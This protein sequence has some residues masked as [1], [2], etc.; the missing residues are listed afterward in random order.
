MKLFF[1]YITIEDKKKTPS[2]SGLLEAKRLNRMI[3]LS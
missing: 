1:I 2:Q 3:L